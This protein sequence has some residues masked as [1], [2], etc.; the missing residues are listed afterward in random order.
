MRS[1]KAFLLGICW[2]AA[3]AAADPVPLTIDV[4]P[5]FYPVEALAARIEGDVPITVK[6]SETGELRC[7]VAP[8][9]APASLKRPSCLLVAARNIFAP[10]IRDGKAIA[11]EY[12][13]VV[14]WRLSRDG[15]QFDG[16]IPIGRAHWITYADYPPLAKSQMLTGK[17][18]LAFDIGAW[19]RIENCRIAHSNATNSL[20]GEMCPLLVRRAMF[21]PAL[22]TE[23][24]PRIAKGTLKTE[25]AWCDSNNWKRCPAPDLGVR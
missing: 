11:Q 6:V 20:A 14:R 5:D 17:V 8:G 19:G 9:N 2:L 7:A 22:T 24:A 3:S 16:A 4:G 18:E 21:L 1:I 25:W 15:R 23:G 10:P 13:F 12:A